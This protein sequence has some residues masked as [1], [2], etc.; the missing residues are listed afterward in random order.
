M[1]R[2]NLAK[3]FKIATAQSLAANFSTSPMNVENLDNVG[4]ILDCKSITDNTGTFAVEVRFKVDTVGPQ[5]SGWGELTLDVVPTLA[6][7][8]VVIPI[9]LNQIPFTEFRITFTAAGGTPN[10]NVDIWFSARQVGG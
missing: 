5:S 2:K 1:A 3:P 10:G 4:I 8:P 9:N 6:D 7:A